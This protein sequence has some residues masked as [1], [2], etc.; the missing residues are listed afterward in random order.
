MPVLILLREAVH[1]KVIRTQSLNSSKTN[2]A[3]PDQSSSVLDSVLALIE[4]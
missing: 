3:T 2:E 1:H 4:T